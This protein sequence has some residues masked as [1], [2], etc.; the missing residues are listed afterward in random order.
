MVR[1]FAYDNSLEKLLRNEL[2]PA[3][4]YIEKRLLLD[5]PLVL[6]LID[7]TFGEPSPLLKE[8]MARVLADERSI[9]YGLEQ[10]ATR[11][12]WPAEKDFWAVLSKG[13]LTRQQR[14]TMRIGLSHFYETNLCEINLVRVKRGRTRRRQRVIKWAT[15]PTIVTTLLGIDL[16]FVLYRHKLSNEQ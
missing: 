9:E 11:A 14:E 6:I 3:A 7:L 8:I 12:K 1:P 16:A 4:K 10:A 5:Q 15:L 13:A 2:L